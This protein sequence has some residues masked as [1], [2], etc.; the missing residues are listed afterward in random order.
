[1]NTV[2]TQLEA[3]LFG[4]NNGM[5]L[6]SDSEAGLPPMMPVELDQHTA[7]H[8]VLKNGDEMAK[9]LMTG[10]LGGLGGVYGSLMALYFL[11]KGDM[12]SFGI[13]FLVASGFVIIP[14]VLEML[15]SLDPPILFNR[16][17]REV[18]VMHED[19]L[20]HAPWDCI[21]ALT[22][23]Y[24][25]VHQNTGAM[26]NAPLE[27]L[28][29]EYQQ[30]EKQLFVSLG[31]PM[32]KTVVM[33]QHFWSYLQAYMDK[34]PWFDEHGQSCESPRH[35]KALL[36]ATHVNRRDEL[37]SNWKMW[38]ESLSGAHF[39]LLLYALLFYPAYAI[40]DFTLAMAKRR[41]RNQWPKEVR[42]RLKP[43]GPTTR[44]V[45][46][47]RNVSCAKDSIV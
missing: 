11:I 34:G 45:D 2:L 26:T 8:L 40:W 7:T 23:E 19:R 36:A 33:Q 5:V 39:F 18:Y 4:N 27:V 28:V 14:F 12:S 25:M 35:I 22:Y 17:T 31:L 46:L 3:R 21:G 29:H 47:E 43:D 32:G 1:M 16:R 13:M 20:Y 37:G 6:R 9:G 42:E 41:T 24:Q 38:R 15:F 44:L 30:V 10:I